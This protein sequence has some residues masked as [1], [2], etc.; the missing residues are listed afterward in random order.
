MN[1]RIPKYT[2]TLEEIDRIRAM[3]INPLERYMYNFNE[4][5][6]E[7]IN[8]YYEENPPEVVLD[9]LG[10]NHQV[11]VPLP[12]KYE[13]KACSCGIIHSWETAASFFLDEIFLHPALNIKKVIK[14]CLKCREILTLKLYKD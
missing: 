11:E 13:K 9:D 12:A 3:S 6:F 1:F 10:I 2:P 14:K 5:E 4:D 8:R 7:K